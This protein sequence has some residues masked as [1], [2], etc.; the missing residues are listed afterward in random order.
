MTA[1]PPELVI[2][3]LTFADLLKIALDDVPGSSAGLWTLHGAVDPGITLLELFAWRFE[4][5]LYAADQ[6]TDSTTRAGLRLLGLADPLPTRAAT[7]V[8]GLR[9]DG[10]AT[11]VEKGAVFE[12]VADAGERGEEARIL[13]T[14]PDRPGRYLMTGADAV[15][16]DQG[17][18]FR[19]DVRP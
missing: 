16:E 2:D 4:Q 6:D 15:R 14:F 8:L 9:V 17:L 12:L 7:T 18:M 13:M 11:G 1:L 5:R 3:D 10:P 19:W